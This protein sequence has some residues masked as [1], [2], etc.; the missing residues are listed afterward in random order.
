M[1]IFTSEEIQ[2]SS[3]AIDRSFA[4]MTKENRGKKSLEI[5]KVVR[6]L[7]DH[8]ADKIWHDIN[9]GKNM[10]LNK[11]ASKMDGRF[12]FISQFDSFLRS[13]VS[14]F[15]PTEDGAERLLIKYYKYLLQLK[16]VMKD[17]YDVDILKNI[18]NFIDDTD[19]QT[20]EYYTKVTVAIDKI[21]D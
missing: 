6:D 20:N 7:N 2:N 13:S 14:H 8:V 15:T 5:V 4:E 3:D 18:R 12:R 1:D 16:Q 10:D 11:V 9:T 19:T 21:L 17:R